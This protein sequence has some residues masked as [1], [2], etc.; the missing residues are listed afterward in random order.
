MT[1]VEPNDSD[2]AVDSDTSDVGDTTDHSMIAHSDPFD[3]IEQYRWWITK[4]ALCAI[5]IVGLALIGYATV[6]YLI[7]DPICH[8]ITKCWVPGAAIQAVIAVAAI[9]TIICGVLGVKRA[10]HHP[11]QYVYPGEY[12]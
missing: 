12:V 10:M 7:V 3:P 2:T 1:V 4:T 8:G 5:L 6:L 9:I 11:A